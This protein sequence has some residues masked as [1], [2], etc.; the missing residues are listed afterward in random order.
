MLAIDPLR[1]RVVVG[2]DA[3][4][5]CNHCEVE[6]VNWIAPVRT[7]GPIRAQ[8][9]VRHKHLPAEATVLAVGETR[10]RV[11]FDLPQRA[12]TPGQAAVFYDGDRVLGGGW[13]R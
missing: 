12:V 10:A 7:E 5:R 4:L 1:N 9:K 8:V 2:E 3:A 13:I 11:S 6:E